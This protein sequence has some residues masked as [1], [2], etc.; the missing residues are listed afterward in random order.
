[1][2]D[3][4]A[5]PT[6][7]ADIL[8][9]PL[10]RAAYGDGKPTWPQGSSGKPC[11]TS[12]EAVRERRLL[13]KALLRNA[14][15][16]ALGLADRL[17][18]CGPGQCCLSGDCPECGRA[19]QRI[20]VHATRKLFDHHGRNMLA[21]NIISP[22][23]AIPYGHLPR[24]DLFAGIRKRL[25]RA[26]ADV[27]VRA[28]GGFD[29]SANE[30]EANA[31]PAHFMPHTYIFVPTASMRRVEEAFRSW[32]RPSKTTP[33]PVQMKP[34]DGAKTGF[35]YALKA[36]FQRRISRAPVVSD[37]GS[38]V[39]PRPRAKAIWGQ[40]RVELAL[41]LDRAGL[42]AR[43]FLRGYQLVASGT[44]IEIVPLPRR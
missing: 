14:S 7:I 32:F 31:F 28:V 41:A 2:A 16:E 35:A 27:G 13:I 44:D 17:K 30:H 39:T 18:Q 19:A 24:Y 10:A 23:R 38:S 4:T 42:D 21:A 3:S 22:R 8:R 12:A 29:V 25:D 6:T 26:L 20:F 11:K 9:G 37:D 36:D 1:M 33:R 34:F 15:P 43:L 40:Q 5:T